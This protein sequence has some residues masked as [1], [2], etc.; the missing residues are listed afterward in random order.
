MN[1]L[2]HLDEALGVEAGR[3][4]HL[5]PQASKCTVRLPISGP[6]STCAFG[7]VLLTQQC[8]LHPVQCA[9]LSACKV[10]FDMMILSLVSH[11]LTATGLP[12]HSASNTLPNPPCP[13]SHGQFDQQL[14]RI[15]RH[16]WNIEPVM[17]ASGILFPSKLSCVW[18]CYE[19]SGAREALPY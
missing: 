13:C 6:S 8:L 9:L 10:G 2:A 1:H 5:P 4:L 17:C 7:K 19:R 3:Q 11:T 16:A 14:Q 15:L 12:R 18:L